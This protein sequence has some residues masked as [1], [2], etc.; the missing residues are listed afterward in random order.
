M[1]KRTAA[2]KQP[3]KKLDM[4]RLV[5]ETNKLGQHRLVIFKD[6]EPDHSAWFESREI[7]HY[8]GYLFT[9]DYSIAG[10]RPG[11][12]KQSMMDSTLLPGVKYAEA[13]V[14]VEASG[15]RERD[16]FNH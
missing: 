13:S 3:P 10:V 12:W 5:H 11:V 9:M 2:S 8:K 16:D 14:L 6:G 15:P 7:G 1:K 4:N